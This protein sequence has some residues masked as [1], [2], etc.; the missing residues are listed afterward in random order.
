[1]ATHLSDRPPTSGLAADAQTFRAA[2]CVLAVNRLHQGDFVEDP[3]D[4]RLTTPHAMRRMS[5]VASLNY[6][7]TADPHRPSDES[8]R[9]VAFLAH[10]LVVRGE[11]P[12]AEDEFAL[13]FHVDEWGDAEGR[14][15]ESAVAV[16]EAA[17]AA[18]EVSA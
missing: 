8:R 1:M 5:I 7:T 12:Y 10:R 3:F 14:T 16:L 4:R 6:V 2:A 13:A 9:A 11:G 18:C 17:A 15:T